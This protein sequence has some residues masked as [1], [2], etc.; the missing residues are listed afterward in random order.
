MTAD[1]FMSEEQRKER[2]VAEEKRLDEAMIPDEF[3]VISKSYKDEGL[4][5][6]TSKFN[7]DE[8]ESMKQSVASSK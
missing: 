4:L 7:D 5:K 6:I 1:D 3:V 8:D 2:K